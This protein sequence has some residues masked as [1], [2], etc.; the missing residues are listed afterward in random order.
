MTNLLFI[1]GSS[2]KQSFNKQLANAA[3]KT[4]QQSPGATNITTRYIDLAHFDI[5]LY[6]GDLEDEFGIPADALRLAAIFT[7]QDGIFIAS[8]EYNGVYSALLKNTIDW[9]FRAIGHHIGDDIGDDNAYDKGDD[10]EPFKD[11]VICLA[12]ASTLDGGGARG[13]I[14]LR[15]LM[16]YM[17]SHVIPNQF[18]LG[19]ADQAFN[20][21]G[22][23]TDQ[24][25]QACL[26]QVLGQFVA[27]T[28]ALSGSELD[29]NLAQT[30]LAYL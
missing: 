3:L 13:L 15:T 8:P 2:R 10:I 28:T 19:N 21:N 4:V 6:N 25:K 17:H 18:T 7:M 14:Q 26:E 29:Q 5:P 9:M 23:I 11:K 12:A 22:N 30:T 1:A 20:A 24:T 16:G 27:T